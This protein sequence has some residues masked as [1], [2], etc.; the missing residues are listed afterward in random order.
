MPDDRFLTTKQSDL[1]V[2][3]FVARERSSGIR[4]QVFEDNDETNYA[5]TFPPCYPFGG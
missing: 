4:N 5:K 1:R 2:I 3:R